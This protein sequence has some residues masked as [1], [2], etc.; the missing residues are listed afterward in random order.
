MRVGHFL[1]AVFMHE[2]TQREKQKFI[3]E[4]LRLQTADLINIQL[5]KS[6]R[7]KP[8]ELWRF[9]WDGDEEEQLSDDEIR[10]RN[11]EILKKFTDG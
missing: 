7:V 4:L 5:K 11:E 8:D 10:R 6:D 2:K 3:A 1:S 9:P